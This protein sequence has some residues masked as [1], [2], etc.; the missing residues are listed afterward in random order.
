VPTAPAAPAV[1]VVTAAPESAADAGPAGRMLPR[2]RA[3]SA[4]PR[5]PPPAWL[6]ADDG[7]NLTDL[8]IVR[9]S[10]APPPALPTG[11]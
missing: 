3:G 6:W 10:S 1:R 5:V 8:P 2:G 7:T 4:K 9:N 11:S